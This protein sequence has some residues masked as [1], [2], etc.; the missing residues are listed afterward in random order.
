MNESERLTCESFLVDAVDVVIVQ[1]EDPK[2]GQVG[3]GPGRHA[4]D[5]VVGEV[6]AR[7]TISKHFVENI[8][9]N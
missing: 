8:S 5:L 7:E 2:V 9:Q 4:A 1:L 3:D 6:P